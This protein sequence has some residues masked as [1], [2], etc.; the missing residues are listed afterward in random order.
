MH[1]A[2]GSGPGTVSIDEYLIG[3]ETLLLRDI[4]TQLCEGIESHSISECS[5]VTPGQDSDNDGVID[6]YDQCPETPIGEVVDEY[7]CPLSQLD[8][9]D[10]GVTDDTDECPDTPEGSEVNEIGCADTDEDGV[11]DNSDNCPNT[12]IGFDV[13]VNGCALYE[14]DSDQD[15]LTDDIDQCNDTAYW[16]YD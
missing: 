9:D 3:S 8:S 15:G 1:Y 10:D 16:C 14:K 5:D 2:S 11:N 4:S 7:G 6:I 13:D 12:Q